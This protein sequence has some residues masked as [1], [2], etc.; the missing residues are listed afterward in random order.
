MFS[1]LGG[2]VSTWSFLPH[3][4]PHFK[5]GN[6]LNLATSTGML[7]VGV[8]LLAFMKWDNKRRD[9][10]SAEEELAGMSQV[11]IGDLDWKNPLFRWHP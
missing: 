2:L 5:I 4:G 7:V 6:G 9:R 10:R 11:E 8:A 1:N 3:D